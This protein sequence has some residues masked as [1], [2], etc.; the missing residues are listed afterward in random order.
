VFTRSATA[1][2]LVTVGF[3]VFLYIVGVTKSL[4]DGIKAEQE[5]RGT[6]NV[7]QWAFTLVE[8]INNVLPRY[9]DLDKLTS[10]LISDGT[11]T[12]AELREFGLATLEFPSWGG[13]FGVS[14]AFIAVMLAISCWRFSRRDY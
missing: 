9:K 6:D 2:M 11:L 4:F 13:T 14:L 8:T 3:S 12:P 7:P 1:A 5:A 10:K